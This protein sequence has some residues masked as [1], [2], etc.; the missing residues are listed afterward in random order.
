[1]RAPLLPGA[2]RFPAVLSAAASMQRRAACVD[3]S[4]IVL[5]LPAAFRR[6]AAHDALTRDLPACAVSPSLVT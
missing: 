5:R 2:R 4:P 6:H 1:M 3:A